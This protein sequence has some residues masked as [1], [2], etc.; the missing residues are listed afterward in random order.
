[1]QIAEDEGFF[2]F[3]KNKISVFSYNL[4]KGEWYITGKMWTLTW[5]KIVEVVHDRKKKL[6]HRSSVLQLDYFYA[7]YESFSTAKNK[8]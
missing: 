4:R 8:K 7:V 3:F 6:L 5:T 1:M 2:F